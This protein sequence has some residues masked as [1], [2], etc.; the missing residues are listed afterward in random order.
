MNDKIV[1]SMSSMHNALIPH[2]IMMS[3]IYLVD[4]WNGGKIVGRLQSS[5]TLGRR[6]FNM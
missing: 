3:K 6:A 4:G 5:A 2:E 1:L